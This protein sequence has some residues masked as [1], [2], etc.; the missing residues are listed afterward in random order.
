[1]HLDTALTL[2]RQYLDERS[3]DASSAWR[4]TRRTARQHIAEARRGW[5]GARSLAT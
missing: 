5:R 1:M 2:W 3:R 4:H